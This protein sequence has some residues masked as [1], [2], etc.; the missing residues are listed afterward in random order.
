[1]TLGGFKKETAQIIL[2][3]VQ[4]LRESGFVIKRP[5]RGE[6]FVPPDAPIYVRNDSGVEIPA[7]GCVQVTGTVEAGGQNYV[8]VDKP[9]DATGDAGGY[10]FNGVAPIEVGGYGIAHDGPVVRMLTDGS[11]VACGDM[12]QPVVNSFLV[13]TGGSMFSA[14]G[15]DDIETDV[16][17]AFTGSGGGGGAATIQF[18]VDSVAT[19]GSSSPYNGKKVA[20]V[21]IEVAPCSRGDL[22][23]TT[24]EVVDWSGCVWDLAEADLIGVWGWATECVAL[25]LKSGDP[26]GTLT[27]CH[28]GADDRCCL[29][30]DV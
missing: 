23:G 27:P 5:G 2:D 12:W 25:S 29:P 21:T 30:E 19:A 22:I 7:F 4:Y 9:V 26:P 8:T 16:M 28:F 11:A 13:S 1:V 3:V 15:E 20:T 14:I 10:L 24:A 18:T 6:Q 17:R